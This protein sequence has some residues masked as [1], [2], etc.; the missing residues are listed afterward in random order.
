LHTAAEIDEVHL[1]LSFATEKLK[2]HKSPGIDQFPAELMKAV[3]G[4]VCH[5]IH[6]LISIWNKD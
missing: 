5:E 4:M 1:K 3:G 2:S 6:K